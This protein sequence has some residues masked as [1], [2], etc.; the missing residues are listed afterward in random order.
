MNRGTDSVIDGEMHKDTNDPSLWKSDPI[1]FH[2]S[3]GKASTT[4]KVYTSRNP[5]PDTIKFS[6]YIDSPGY[7]YDVAT[8]DRI[9]GAN[10]WLQWPDG[11]GAWVNVPTGLA[12]MQLDMNPITTKSNGQDQWDVLPGSYRVHVEAP[13]YFPA[14]SIVVI[15]TNT[16]SPTCMLAEREGNTPVPSSHQPSS[17]RP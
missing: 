17:Q 2:P 4:Y 6:F 1:T 8:G 5:T 12:V 3:H 10:V 11:R 9:A 13:G 16:R 7:I 14:D 15:I